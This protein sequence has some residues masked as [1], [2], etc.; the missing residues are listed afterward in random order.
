MTNSKGY[1]GVDY[2]TLIGLHTTR[3]GGDSSYTES[4]LDPMWDCYIGPLP[5]LLANKDDDPY[6]RE[7]VPARRERLDQ[8]REAGENSLD[9]NIWLRSQTS[10]HYGA[11]QAYAEPLETD[12]DIARFRF[13]QSGGINPWTPGSVSLL[14]ETASRTTGARHCFGV[15]GVGVVVSTDTDGVRKFPASGAS[16]QLSTKNTVTSLTASSS[17]WFGIS[18]AGIEYGDLSGATGEGQMA[19]TGLESAC[20]TRDRLIA[21]TGALVYEITSVGTLPAAHHTFT[22][23]V[24]A[25][26]DSG[27]GGIYILRNEDV[28]KVY[29]MTV[30][31]DGSLG[32]PRE[33]AALPKGEVGNFIYGYLGRYL[34]IGT[35]KGVRVADCSSSDSLPIGPL[36]PVTGGVVDAVGAGD[37]IWFTAGTEGV[38]PDVDETA[39]PGLWRMDLSRQLATVSAYGDSAAARYAYAPDMYA[40]TTGAVYSVTF[41]ADE[42]YF[43]AGS[44]I[45][46]A[47][48]Y[49]QQDTLV[50]QG[51]VETGEINFSTAENKSYLSIGSD[52]TGAGYYE[53]S[54]DAGDG[55][56]PVIQS[57][58][59]VPY[60]GDVDFDGTLIPVS[61]WM[62]YRVRLIGTGTG[63]VA[64][65]PTLQS[66]VLRATPAP[67]RTRYIRL[68]PSCHD[69]AMDRNNSPVGYEG[70]G[71]D[72][73][74]DLEDLE[75]SGLLLTF[76][77][78]R[79]GESKRCQIDRI[80]YT[81]TTPPSRS[82]SNFGGVVHVTLLTV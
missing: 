71:Y 13:H 43:I 61:N 7:S 67:K 74:R 70:F 59:D 21:V 2:R 58:I 37:F 8:S 46:D 4:V 42:V 78:N 26:V 49:Q 68:P 52:V 17:R 44:A 1:Y 60:S 6:L 19:R 69:S 20:W 16:T 53:L 77:D 76:V 47:L 51:W 82:K 54:A 29:V 73:L 27:S 30:A 24:S 18:T 14:P 65:S 50:D 45:T 28:T 41:Y 72:R 64:D 3:A 38:V 40:D 39:L 33:V 75:E 10:W 5:F 31:D 66:I 57:A 36:I 81:G 79:T 11:G 23:G 22:S 80:Q 55:Y 9:N 48:L 15:N 34:V 62:K 35:D 63:L 56:N 25:D 12:P 32:V